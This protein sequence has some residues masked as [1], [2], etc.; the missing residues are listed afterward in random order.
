[1]AGSRFRRRSVYFFGRDLEE[2]GSE[3]AGRKR[4]A[5]ARPCFDLARRRL[6]SDLDLRSVPSPPLISALVTP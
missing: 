2:G 1:L 6:G 3:R 5:R 4:G